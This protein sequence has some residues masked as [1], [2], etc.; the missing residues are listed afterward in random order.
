MAKQG[1]G[2]AVQENKHA[3]VGPDRLYGTLACPSPVGIET[4]PCESASR[5]RLRRL[6]LLLLRRLLCLSDLRKTDRQTEKKARSISHSFIRTSSQGGGGISV[7]TEEDKTDQ[8]EVRSTSASDGMASSDSLCE[9]EEGCRRS[10]AGPDERRR[11]R[12]RG[13]QGAS[14]LFRKANRGSWSSAGGFRSKRPRPRSRN[15]T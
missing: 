3:R 12:T 5:R 13:I 10:G 1:Q 14:G 8:G 15:E 2:R 11:A 7:W 6:R 9:E 4:P